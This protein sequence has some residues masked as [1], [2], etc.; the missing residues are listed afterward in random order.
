MIKKLLS[1]G[2]DVKAKTGTGYTPLHLINS[3]ADRH[4]AQL[5]LEKGADINVENNEKKS[6]HDL[7]DKT[8]YKSSI[9]NFNFIF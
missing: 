8:V 5:L 6:P 3:A 2:A 9:F 7:A 1:L 4:I